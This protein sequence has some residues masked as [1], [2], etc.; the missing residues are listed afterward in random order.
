M[1]PYLK[2]GLFIIIALFVQS[3]KIYDPYVPKTVEKKALVAQ[4]K[5]HVNALNDQN[6]AGLES[7]YAQD[8]EGLFPVTH[9]KNKTEL[10]NIL[11]ENQKKN[12]I[13]IESKI[14]EIHARETMGYALL[15]W[16]AIAF[17]ESEQ[18][19]ILY[20]RKHFQIWEKD[21][22]KNWKLKRSLFY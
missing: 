22:K 9:F 15:H 12:E 11:L 21:D 18:E 13:R 20:E 2:T 10:I 17:P 7:V 8:Y 19:E 5:V 3:C 16:V 4:I 6:R 1:K 14:L